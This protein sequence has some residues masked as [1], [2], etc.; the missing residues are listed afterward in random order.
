MVHFGL[1]GSRLGHSLSPQIHQ[2]IFEELGIE[3]TYDLMEIAP[4]ELSAGVH[5]LRGKYGGVNVTIPHKINV[6]AS[7]TTLSMAAQCIGAVNTIHFCCNGAIRGY[8]TDYIGF[9]R[10]L[11]HNGIEVKNKSVAVLGTGGVARAVLQYLIDHEVAQLFLVSRKPQSVAPYMKTLCSSV[12]TEFV[13]Y[14]HLQHRTGDLLVNCTPVGMYPKVDASPVNLTT[15]EHFAAAVDLIYNP[16]RT[17]FLQQAEQLGKPAVNGLFMLVAQ[18]VASE[19]IWLQREISSDVV[20]NVAAK[21]A[22][23]L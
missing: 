15:M 18:A 21:I 10:L 23:Q 22:R 14:L 3:G 20:F 1:I 8:N 19:E 16:A 9:G 12:P 17:L 5:G 4:E 11:E 6:M 13:N 2:L 7:V